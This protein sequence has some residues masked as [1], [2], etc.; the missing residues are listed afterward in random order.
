MS[1]GTRHRHPIHLAAGAASI[2]MVAVAACGDDGGPSTSAVD[3]GEQSTTTEAAEPVIDP[4]DGG[5]YDPAIDPAAFVDVIDNPYLPYAPGASWI[6]EGTEDGETERIE[7]TVTPERKQIM[8]ISATVVRDTVTVD[9]E[10]VEDTYDW[11]AQD[12]D[13]NVWYLGEDSTEFENG[14]A[15]SKAGSWEAGVDGAL[16]G[17]VMQADPQVGQAYRQEYYPGEAE[18][19]ARVSRLGA[20]ESVPFRDFDQLLVIEE[21]N[22]LEPDV[23]EEKYFAPDVGLV[24]EVKTRGGEGRVE[25]I[26]HNPGG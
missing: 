18:D 26:D 5:N 12:R 11:F 6:Y 17:I 3:E 7:V 22:P 19:L 9:G 10:L 13:G 21:W 2:L 25:L 8:G 16:P 20:T 4:G 24:L 1:T 14:E 15:V 23:V